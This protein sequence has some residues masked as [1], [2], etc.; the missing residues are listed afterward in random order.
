MITGSF[1][2]ELCGVG[3]YTERL[4]RELAKLGIDVYL[5]T[6]DRPEIKD[7]GYG[8]VNV[9]KVIKSWRL[10][11]LLVLI[12]HLKAIQ[13][14]LIHIQYPTRGYRWHLL[15]NFLPLVCIFML[16]RI[17]RIVT[18]H[19]FTIAHWLRKVGMVFLLLFSTKISFPDHRE[20]AAVLRWFPWLRN[21]C[22]VIP[23]GSN[24]EPR[25]YCAIGQ[26]LMEKPCL[27]YFGFSTRSKDITTLIHAFQVLLSESVQC[28]LLMITQ[29][30]KK[31]MDWIKQ[32]G[33]EH[34]ITVTGYCP[35]DEV[36]NYLKNTM[37]CVLPFTDGVSMR[38]GTFIAALQHGLPVVTTFGKE[39]PDV[40]KN[41]ENV[42]LTPVGDSQAMSQAI[43][44]LIHNHD[45]IN[46]I[47]V[48]A[49]KLGEYFSWERIGQL[50]EAL[51]QSVC[52]KS[53]VL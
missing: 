31:D 47:S 42:I 25:S 14:D 35:P 30:P 44:K 1:P 28:K 7:G 32:L 21:Q 18:I 15:V 3:D 41:W 29:L 22:M 50:H 46:K 9:E 39:V 53:N 2:N 10:H 27:V 16:P 37:I 38:R 12:R 8:A 36:S 45:L 13:P 33:L 5:L 43:L 6:T 19:E 24:I 26:E 11:N 49:R 20:K 34:A 17:P 51:Y 48:N 23:I 40:L 4:S 52:S